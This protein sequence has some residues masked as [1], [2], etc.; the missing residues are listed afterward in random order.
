VR[1]K[2]FGCN[3][4]GERLALGICFLGKSNL[5]KEENAPQKKKYFLHGGCI[6]EIK[7]VSL[8]GDFL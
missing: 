4:L 5:G 2:F 8:W 1:A 7:S 3:A 6:Q